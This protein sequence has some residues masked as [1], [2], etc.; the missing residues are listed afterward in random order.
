MPQGSIMLYRILFPCL[1]LLLVAIF[2]PRLV[3][4]E[5]SGPYQ[6]VRTIDGDTIELLMDGKPEKVRLIGV[7]TPETVHPSKGVEYFGKEASAFTRDLLSGQHVNLDFDL[8]QRDRYGRLLAYVYRASDGLFVN[9]E[10]VR[11]GYGH[12]Y[13][14]FPFKFL[15]E[16][17]RA[18]QEAREARRGL[19]A[20]ETKS[21]GIKIADSA[22]ADSI[23]F[24]TR[25][26]TKYHREGCRHLSGD[27]MEMAL[28]AAKA[29]YDPCRICNP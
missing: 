20:G 11:Q 12:A 19:W 6:I 18:E 4:D 14:R 27:R 21:A 9:R 17:R 26:G 16:F 5:R 25:S 13:T 15:D 1:I 29:D 24:V 7:D 8:E 23:V 10:I 22:T 2:Y 3:D 28:E